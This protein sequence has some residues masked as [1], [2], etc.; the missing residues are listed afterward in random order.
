MEFGLNDQD[1]KDLGGRGI[2]DG[3]DLSKTWKNW[4]NIKRNWIHLEDCIS[5]LINVQSIQAGLKYFITS[6]KRVIEH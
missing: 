5:D 4:N 1:F 3:S 6:F 2:L